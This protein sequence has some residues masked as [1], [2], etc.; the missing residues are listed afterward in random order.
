VIETAHERRYAGQWA[1]LERVGWK[2]PGRVHYVGV[3]GAYL[4]LRVRVG[5]PILGGKV[6]VYGIAKT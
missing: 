2:A 6:S 1:L 5:E 4:A 3:P